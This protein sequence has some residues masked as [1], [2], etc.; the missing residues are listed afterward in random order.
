MSKTT[1]DEVLGRSGSLR[2]LRI[3]LA[4]L[5]RR[6]DLYDATALPTWGPVP[7]EAGSGGVFSWDARRVLRHQGDWL[8]ERQVWYEDLVSDLP[9]RFRVDR[10]GPGAGHVRTFEGCSASTLDRIMVEI[11]CSGDAGSLEITAEGCGF[12]LRWDAGRWAVD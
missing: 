12:V 6:G 4:Y 10:L 11:E 1:A 3:T 8:I 9:P 2:D 5:D 7:D